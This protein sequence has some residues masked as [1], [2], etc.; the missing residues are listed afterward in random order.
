ML[1]KGG[2]SPYVQV[3][4]MPLST[5]MPVYAPAPLQPTNP[6][7][8]VTGLLPAEALEPEVQSRVAALFNQIHRHV[9]THYRDV[10]ATLTPSMEPELAMF[11]A[12][13]VNMAELLQD[14]S[15]PTTAIKHALMV[16][17]LSITGPKKREEGETIFPEELQ[18]GQ[19]Q[20]IAGSGTSV[21]CIEVTFPTMLTYIADPKLRTAS[22]LHRRLS[23]YLFAAT[24][25]LSNPRRSR[26]A[27][28]DVREAA[29]HFSLTFFPWAIPGGDDHDK[30]AD[31]T[32]IIAETLET[33]IWLFGQ[34]HVYEFRW[35]GVGQRGVAISPE[36][37]RRSD[38]DGERN[39][40]LVL[41]SG[42]AAI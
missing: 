42:V 37:V 17:V 41:E 3:S 30:D 40:R 10:H 7:D 9:E 27:Q 14:C 39:G 19:L 23:V 33:R 15:H 36:L 22:T 11:G 31:L 34:P 25:S 26:H 13:G 28:S 8:A 35:D 29:E 38:E 1:Q 6:P 5:P 4:Q 16:Y 32:R 2:S 24:S 21:H 20:R 18:G 12:Q